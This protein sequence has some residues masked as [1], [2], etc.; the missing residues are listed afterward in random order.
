MGTP[1]GYAQRVPRAKYAPSNEEVAARIAE[2]VR[3]Y[4]AWRALEAD[5]KAALAAVHD[6]A[7]DDVP[8]SHLAEQI[9]VERKSVY[10]HLGRKMP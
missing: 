8:V 3:L 2:V 5:Y 6:P 9:G 1:T 10:R 4:H 7:K